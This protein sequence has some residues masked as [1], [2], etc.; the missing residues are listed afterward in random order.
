MARP[1]KPARLA[2]L[3]GEWCIRDGDLKQRLGLGKGQDEAAEARL[4][5]YLL[6][7]RSTEKPTKQRRADRISCAEVLDR[8]LTRKVVARP[9][10][11]AQRVDTLLDFWGEMT[12]DEV[13]EDNCDEFVVGVGSPSYGRRCLED[14]RAAV[15]A[16]AKA[17]F[18][19]DLVKF[20]LPTKPRGRVDWLTYDEVVALV[21]TAWSYR[22]VQRGAVTRRWPTRHIAKFVA[23]GVATCSRSARI[24]EASYVAEPGRPWVDLA[25][26]VYYRAAPDEK[27]AHNKRA[28]PITLSPRLQA[29][30]LR[31]SARGDH[32]V[33][34]FAGRP[35]DTKK[36]FNSTVNRAR[37]RYP[38]LFR[39]SDG[40]PKHV[41]RH[42][43][44]HTG[45][46]WLAMAGVD[47]Y[48]ICGYAGLT[49]E[50]FER[51]YAHH[52]PDYQAGVRKAQSKKERAPRE[53]VA[54]PEMAA[55]LMLPPPS[56]HVAAV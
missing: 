22:E 55:L 54:I 52:H 29:S 12:L 46:T 49:I 10:E 45:V 7:K 25:N 51:I 33:C 32:Y 13:D 43:L 5:A 20:T 35:A 39:R 41:V 42:I 26:G 53:Q 17:G 34:Q 4:E 56:D 23:I 19:R 8:Y 6:A 1:R 2:F 16:Y 9:A 44:R 50:T 28:P 48:E 11:L 38:H 14:F 21:R 47:P 40:T 36:A 18:L 37:K 27:V 24:Y 30:M 3:E 15:N 31:W